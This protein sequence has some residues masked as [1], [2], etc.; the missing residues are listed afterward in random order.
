MFYLLCHGL[1]RNCLEILNFAIL[2][3]I[4]PIM[5][6]LFTY[7][8]SRDCALLEAEKTFKKLYELVCAHGETEAAVW[9]EGDE[10]KSL[11]FSDLKRQADNWSV[12]L[13]KVFGNEG[14]VCISLDS[15][16]EWFPL[17]WGLLRS[18]HDILALDASMP[19]DK[20]EKLMAECNCRAIVSGRNHRLSPDIRQALVSDFIN[21]PEVDNYTPVWGHDVALC[22]SG[23]TSGGRIFVYDEETI[24]YLTLFTRKIHDDN[25]LLIDDCCLRTL[26][27]LPFHHIFGFT[28][29]IWS[30]FLGFTLIFLKDRSPLTIMGT[31]QKCRANQI[32]AVP[33]LANSICRSVMARLSGGSILKRQLF[34]GLVSISLAIQSFA[35]KVGLK[36]ARLMF[37]KV[38]KQ[39]FGTNM[40]SIGLGGSHTEP[41]S[42]RLLNAIGYYTICGYG[43]TETAINSFESSFRL[44]NRLLGSIGATMDYTEYKIRELS[45]KTGTGGDSK[46]S[47]RT[48][49]LLVRGKALHDGRFVNGKLLPPDIDGDGWFHTGDIIRQDG[50]H[51]RYFIEGRIKD[52]IINESGENVYP[53]ELEDAFYCIRDRYAILGLRKLNGRYEDITL[54]VEVGD[55][56]SDEAYVQNLSRE[57]MR[58][59]STLPAYKRLARAIVTGGPMPLTSTMKVRR[60]SLKE[61]IEAGRLKYRDIDIS[62]RPCDGEAI[63]PESENAVRDEKILSRVK[64]IYSRVLNIP[65]DAIEPDANFIGD[66]GGDSLQILDI[67]TGVEDMFGV[68][69]PTECYLDCTTVNGTVDILT[70]LGN[71]DSSDIEGK[72]QAGFREYPLLQAQYGVFIQCMRLP[73]SMQYNLPF[74]SLLSRKVDLDRLE[75]AV[76]TIFEKRPVLH[77]RFRVDEEGNVWQRPDMEMECPMSRCRMTEDE[78]EKYMKESFVTPFNLL[79]GEPLI[80]FEILE[81]DSQ[82]YL[83]VQAHHIIMDGMSFVTNMSRELNRAYMG[84]PLEEQPYTMFDAAVDEAAGKESQEYMRSKEY[85]AAKMAGLEFVTLTSAGTDR[86]GRLVRHSVPVDYEKV[87]GWCRERGIQPILPFQAAFSY[88]LSVLTRQRKLAYYSIHHGRMDRRLRSGYGMFIKPMTIVND[89]DPDISVM[90]F[91]SHIKSEN[92]SSLRNMAYPFSALCMDLHLTPGISFN[93]LAHDKYKESFLLGD[94]ENAYW[95]PVRDDTFD[96]MDCA[97]YMAD[98]NYEIRVES[99]DKVN[100]K[101][102][103]T[104][105]AEAVG[106]TLR[107]MMETP[108][109]PLREIR[110]ISDEQER[111]ILNMGRG[112]VKA[113]DLTKTFVD[114]FVAQAARTP[115]ATAVISGNGSFTYA[116]LDRMSDSIANT[117]LDNGCDGSGSP[118]ISIMLGREKEFVA[119]AIAVEKTGFAYV[120]LDSE[121][122]DEQL[123]YVLSD[124]ESRILITSNRIYEGKTFLREMGDNL[125]V[126]FIDDIP[127]VDKYRPVNRSTPEGMAYMIYTSGSTGTSK[128]VMIPHSAKSHLVQFIADEWWLDRDSRICC[129]SNFAFDASVEDLYPVLTVGGTL[130]IVPEQERKDLALLHRYIVDNGITG[131]CYTTQLGVMLLR[132][133][134]DLPVKYLVVGGEKLSTI[135]QCGTR[136]INTYGPTEFTVDATFREL[137]PDDDADAIPIGRP[138]PNIYALVM[139]QFGHLLPFGAKGELCLAGP[140]AAAGY[141]KREKLTAEKFCRAG[142]KGFEIPVYHTGDLVRW[143]NDRNLEY[144]GR[145]DNQVKLCGFRVELGGIES[146]ICKYPGIKSAVVQIREL[147]GAARIVAWFTADVTVDTTLLYEYLA[148]TLAGHTVPS[149]YMQLDGFPLTPNGKVDVRNLPDPELCSNCRMEPPA[150]DKEAELFEIASQLVGHRDFGVTDNLYYIGMTSLMT[151]QF[152]A[153]AQMKGYEFRVSDVMLHRTI[154]GII[155]HKKRICWWFKDFDP[156]KPTMLFVHGIVTINDMLPKLE[157]WSRQVNLLCI[158][159]TDQHCE[160][161]SQENQDEAVKLYRT[162]INGNLPQDVTISLFFGFSWGGELAYLIGQKYAADTGEKP[163]IIMGDSHLDKKDY[164]ARDARAII[165]IMLKRYENSPAAALIEKKVRLVGRMQRNCGKMPE[166]EG[167][168]ILMNALKTA[169]TPGNEHNISLWRRIAPNLEVIDMDYEHEELS[170]NQ[171][172]I[173]FYYEL[174]NQEI[175]QDIGIDVGCHIVCNRREE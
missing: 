22:T 106:S 75:I 139:D 89:V 104:M 1:F 9:L 8:V 153:T 111:D 6:A 96:D 67:I 105:L 64:G 138:L 70:R 166:Y 86:L 171:K 37:Y 41:E 110:I 101:E 93:F 21:C 52:V 18:G 44:G 63:P 137:A 16:K 148:A 45:G 50:T 19:D 94:T 39:I 24:C 124:S 35:P 173:P 174:L 43:M 95:Q 3:L 162:L 152:V 56:I 82:N 165:H 167:R 61:M 14:R 69:V 11:T 47:Y 81:T 4:R 15:C 149:A 159:P 157:S 133:Y 76:R 78:A 92:F 62:F 140:Q 119:A 161:F 25:R 114:M 68:T 46:E 91:I 136:L 125:R 65:A 144:H 168:V 79:G 66:L 26:A 55:S 29:F 13:A 107:R 87:N 170:S 116:E 127:A 88:V 122:P 72:E 143:N 158:E 115:D 129:H 113:Y 59:N 7:D 42:L 98:G 164:L 23:T 31:A 131:G 160:M 40:K 20:V 120:P 17:F 154:R 156:T 27:F 80:R 146:Q 169:V 108:D 102:T 142:I 121:Y 10:E 118:F 32:I 130:F 51:G 155:G 128:G 33:V 36:I 97:I 163:V 57:I 53:D 150:D 123:T 99:S 84:E 48:G 54:A 38:Q 85:F 90:E 112:E 71:H 132:M 49:E 147:S 2:L 151:M 100:S 74:I 172:L 60:I 135:P 134:P 30:H 117:I 34:K 175:N 103:V 126:L 12:A 109:A 145:L 28:I 141:W 77:A 58:V 83:L 73:G 5:P